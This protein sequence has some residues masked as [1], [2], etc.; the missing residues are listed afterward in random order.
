MKLNPD[1]LSGYFEALYSIRDYLLQ[2][3][4][5]Y[6]GDIS[7]EEMLLLMDNKITKDYVMKRKKIKV[8]LIEGILTHLESMDNSYKNAFITFVEK[9]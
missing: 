8:E 7:M 2:L 4:T 9:K 1:T 6:N 3:K 5:I